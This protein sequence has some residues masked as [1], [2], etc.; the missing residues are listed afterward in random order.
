MVYFEDW[1][2]LYPEITLRPSLRGFL[3]KQPCRKQLS[4]NVT[5]STTVRMDP[6]ALAKPQSLSVPMNETVLGNLQSKA[7]YLGSSKE[8]QNKTE[9]SR[10][11]NAGMSKGCPHGSTRGRP[12]ATATQLLVKLTKEPDA[13]VKIVPS[14][15]QH[16]KPATILPKR[17]RIDTIFLTKIISFQWISWRKNKSCLLW[18]SIFPSM[19]SP[20][21]IF[22]LLYFHATLKANICWIWSGWLH[23]SKQGEGAG[24]KWDSSVALS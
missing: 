9:W 11:S 19:S 13:P 17:R 12:K 20:Q 23:I 22:L 15:N 2:L 1:K 24:G 8:S 18:T 3:K 4:A 6:W 16:G 7:V 5:H 21:R 10:K 14:T